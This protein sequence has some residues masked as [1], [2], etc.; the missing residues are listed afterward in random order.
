MKRK[1]RH[2][3]CFPFPIYTLFI[4]IAID[5]SYRTRSFVP[6]FLSNIVDWTSNA[7]NGPGEFAV[8]SIFEI[9]ANRRGK[10]YGATDKC[11]RQRCG[12]G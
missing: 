12:G 8:Q 3:N 11:R 5:A 1:M 6:H 4:V 9:V 2:L 10:T 7:H